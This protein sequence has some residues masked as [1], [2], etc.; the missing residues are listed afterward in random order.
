[1]TRYSDILND[2][3]GRHIDWL[4]RRQMYQDEA[5]EDRSDS[6]WSLY[7]FDEDSFDGRVEEAGQAEGQRQAWVESAGFDGVDALTR[8][9]EFF[10]QVGLAPVALGAEDAKTVLHWFLQSLNSRVL[11]AA[12]TKMS[13]LRLPKGTTAG[14]RST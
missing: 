9:F 8:D 7:L 10:G 1:M 14:W 2:V 3:F 5:Q 4:P 11:V 13:M 12:M 6:D